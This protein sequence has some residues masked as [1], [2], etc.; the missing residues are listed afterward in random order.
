MNCLFV[1]ASFVLQKTHLRRNDG[2]IDLL[3]I[4]LDNNG[5]NIQNKRDNILDNI[6]DNIV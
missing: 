6:L 3:Y 1:R 5:D 4:F 2:D